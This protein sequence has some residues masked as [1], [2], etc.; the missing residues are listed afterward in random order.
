[1][2]IIRST[3]FAACLLAGLGTAFSSIDTAAAQ[4][5]S[6]RDLME[7]EQ[8][9]SAENAA[10]FNEGVAAYDAGDF[11]R[12]FDL[13]LPIAQEN[14]LAA[15]RNVAILLREG[16][17]VAKDPQRALYFFERA[18]RAGLVSAQVN[19]AFMYLNGE[20]TAQD[21]KTASF[22]FHAAAI[23]GVPAARYNLGVLYERGLGVE[24][25]SARA[26]AWYALAAQTGHELALKRLTEL[27]PSLPGPDPQ[28]EEDRAAAVTAPPPAE[29]QIDTMT[30]SAP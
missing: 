3:L 20:G 10:R 24:Q 2:T 16:K 19:A 1:M 7:Q 22:W 30:S 17:G 11:S 15:M 18:G 12:A 26:L 28:K 27:V 29:A 9:S 23:A 4:G 25:D 13:W 6:V 8:P 21:Y 14:D 5:V